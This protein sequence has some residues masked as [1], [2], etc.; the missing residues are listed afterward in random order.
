MRALFLSI[1]LT[2]PTALLSPPKKLPA[3]P[4]AA[5]THKRAL[6][7]VKAERDKETFVLSPDDALS[8]R[9]IAMLKAR[10][11]REGKK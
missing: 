5:E 10:Q 4:G 2:F 8:A 1:F 3:L 7:L 11:E 6:A 9:K